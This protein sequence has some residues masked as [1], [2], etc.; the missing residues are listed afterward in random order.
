V[1]LTENEYD[2]IAVTETWL[3]N[4]VYDSEL[5]LKNFK[6]LKIETEVIANVEGV[7]Y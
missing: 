5:F 4:S 2:A 1:N 7:Y 3:S 6:F